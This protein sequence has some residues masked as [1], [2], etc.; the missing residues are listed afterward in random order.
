[1]RKVDFGSVCVPAALWLYE[2]DSLAFFL[3]LLHQ[4]GGQA[5]GNP[6]YESFI[7]LLKRC[8]LMKRGPLMMS[9]HSPCLA[10]ALVKFSVL[11]GCVLVCHAMCFV[12]WCAVPVSRVCDPMRTCFGAM[13]AYKQTL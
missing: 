1:M 13:H 10:H 6:W 7:I 4:R 12:S 11:F 2:L 8:Y 5:V 3:L 9:S